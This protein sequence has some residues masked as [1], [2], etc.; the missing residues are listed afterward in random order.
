RCLNY[1]LNFRSFYGRMSIIPHFCSA[2]LYGIFQLHHA[3]DERL[4]AVNDQPEKTSPPHASLETTETPLRSP[5]R[6]SRPED[7]PDAHDTQ[8][9]VTKVPQSGL[10]AKGAQLATGQAAAVSKSL[11]MA[12]VDGDETPQNPQM[13]LEQLRGKMEVVATEFAQGK[14]NRAQFNAIYG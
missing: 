14:L 12:K 6:P 2:Q 5:I 11:E 8:P 4:F 13:A 1:W 9:V 10:L 7:P 3:L